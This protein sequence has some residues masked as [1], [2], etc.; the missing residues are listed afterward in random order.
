[1]PYFTISVLFVIG[2][3]CLIG[4][5]SS[6]R[7][8][9]T[10][11][12]AMAGRSA[13]ST[14]VAGVILGALVAGGSTIGT[15]QMAYE[16]GL[17]AWWFTLG[18][19][20]GCIILGVWFA[21]PVRRSG[22]STLPEFMEKNFG[23]P[24]ALIT[25]IGSILG[26]LISVV[27]Q[28][29]AGKA[30]IR[31][32]FPVS[33]GAAAL[34]LSILILAF[35]FAG[36]LKSYSAVGNAKTLLLYLLLAA[37]CAM[38]SLNGQ[39]PL[40]LFR[41]MPLEP[42]FNPFARGVGAGL[43][44]GFSLVIGI[45]CTQI[46]MQAVFAASNERSARRGCIIAG[47]L[48]PPLGLMCIWTGVAM[49][50]AGVQTEAA[51]ALPYFLNAYFHPAVAGI[52]WAGLAITVVGGASGLC[53]GVATNLS[54]DIY[55]RLSG[56]DRDDPRLLPVSRAAVVLTVFA[57]AVTALFAQSSY[58]LQL[59]YIGMGLRGSG[60][61]VPFVMAI[62]R[63]GSISRRAA[64]FSSLFGLAG[65]LAA[66]AFFPQIEPLFAGTAFSAALVIIFKVTGLDSAK[67]IK[68]KK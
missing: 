36:G 9:D 42:W 6:G 48:I 27:A 32:V 23:Y 1:M 14:A 38:A 20:I 45:L 12:Y 55:P 2:I 34:I 62:L 21:G 49:S 37:C 8:K 53:L 5:M 57:A 18:S 13:G 41:D 52:F 56:R 47:F 39:T 22:L 25:M 7:I 30:L 59:S 29:V 31:S 44:A 10:A 17:S 46:Y 50:H 11:D 4:A 35:I 54:L 68:Y 15:V 3:F 16:L 40:V 19:G 51:Q 65:M 43:G 63:P 61:V 26:T 66:W 24:T 64:F 28:F 60:M 58:I 33:Q 67:Y